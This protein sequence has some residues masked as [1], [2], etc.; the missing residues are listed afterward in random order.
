MKFQ[1][2]DWVLWY[3]QVGRVRQTIKDKVRVQMD[4]GETHV[5]TDSYLAGHQV[6]WELRYSGFWEYSWEP[7]CALA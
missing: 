2:G 3:G 4:T 5:F 6:P 7:L 1:E